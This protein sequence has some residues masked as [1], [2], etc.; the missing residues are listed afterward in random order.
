MIFSTPGATNYFRVVNI[1]TTND[2]SVQY[3]LTLSNP[4][5]RTSN[6]NIVSDNG[7]VYTPISYF[8]IEARTS[9]TFSG[10]MVDQYGVVVPYSPQYLSL[11]HSS[12]TTE[13]LVQTNSAGWYSQTLTLPKCSGG[14]MILGAA[15]STPVGYNYPERVPA[16]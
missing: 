7:L 12:G 15:S 14:G 16:P 10:T 5:H 11:K 9:I 1:A 4:P 2:P 3:T 13:M 8:G 6:S